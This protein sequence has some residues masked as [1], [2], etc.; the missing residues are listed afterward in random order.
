MSATTA[1]STQTS[2]E[3]RDRII[4]VATKL[5]ATQG[6]GSTSV[7]EVVE[8]VGVTKPT[9]YYYFGSKEGLFLAVVNHHMQ[10]GRDLFEAALAGEGSV[11]ERLLSFTRAYLQEV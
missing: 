11:R 5:F 10:I 6:Y 8:A 9:L 3:V 1:H 4:E 2:N 7:R